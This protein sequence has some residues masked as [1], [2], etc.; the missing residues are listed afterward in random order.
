MRLRKEMIEYL[1][2]KI[3]GLLEEREMIEIET[4]AEKLKGVINQIITEDLLV[5]DKLND[6]VR[7]LLQEHLDEVYKGNVDYSKMFNMIKSKLVR[8][9]GL[10]L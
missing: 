4:D 2:K 5:E 7:E 3:V 9:R 8:E 1:S 10:I 6:E